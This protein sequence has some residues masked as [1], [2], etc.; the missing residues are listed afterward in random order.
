MLYKNV[1]GWALISLIFD[2]SDRDLQKYEKVIVQD[3]FCLSQPEL[4]NFRTY[5]SLASYKL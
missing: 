5:R 2:M 4:E 3:S 1:F